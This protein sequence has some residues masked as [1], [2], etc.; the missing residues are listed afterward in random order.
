MLTFQRDEGVTF[1]Y[2]F[3]SFWYYLR[4]FLLW[5]HWGIIV[6]VLIWLIHFAY[7]CFKC[8]YVECHRL[9]QQKRDLT[10]VQFLLMLR[11][12]LFDMTKP[13][14]LNCWSIL[15]FKFMS[16]CCWVMLN[17]VSILLQ[18]LTPFIRLFATLFAA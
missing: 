2:T 10:L 12:L 18:K 11:L 7:I 16:M 3:W 15:V 9:N 6:G 5:L 17:L 14:L 13:Y 8:Y 4:V 1:S